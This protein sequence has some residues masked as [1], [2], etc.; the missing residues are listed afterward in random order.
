MSATV[1]FDTGWAQIAAG[2]SLGDVPGVEVDAEDRVYA[3]TRG[4]AAVVVFDRDGTVL[5]RWD[6]GPF[7]DPHGLRVAPD[8]MLWL[9]DDVDH[10][11][12]RCTIE[13]EVLQTIGTPGKPAPFMSGRPFNKPNNI[14]F[15]PDGD[16]FVVDGY[17]NAH[18]HRM[19]HDGE[20]IRTW[21][22]SGSDPGQFYIPHDI[23]CDGE[24]FVYVADRENHRIQV[25]DGDGTVQAV[26]Y[27][28]HRPAGIALAGDGAGRRVYVAELAPLFR[29]QVPFA[30]NLGARVS[31]LD[32][33]GSALARYGAAD[34]GTGSDQFIAP[35]G[36]A[37]DSHGDVYVGEVANGQWP[38]YSSE[39]APSSLTTLR[40]LSGLGD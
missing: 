14:A 38:A 15:G 16:I 35:H 12:R 23:R 3:F 34:A 13:G 6:R 7:A 9:T 1:Q 36:I 11:I 25:F 20:L 29:N 17:G 27:G 28:L 31:V 21:G 18:V 4:E 39:P 2:T 5:H 32:G 22:G 10:T 37:V 30:P 40:K 26:W 8:G 33:N 24:G 19:T